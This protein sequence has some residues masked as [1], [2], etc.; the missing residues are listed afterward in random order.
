[1]YLCIYVYV[2]VIVYLYRMH[3]G[4]CECVHMCCI[5]IEEVSSGP[6]E[7]STRPLP[8]WKREVMEHVGT[9]ALQ[10]GEADYIL[11]KDHRG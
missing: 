8:S 5:N 2:C 4:L 10:K 9:P 11:Q 3:E 6:L 7:N 1:M